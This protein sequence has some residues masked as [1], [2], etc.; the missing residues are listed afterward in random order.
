MMES[1]HPSPMQSA[2]SPESPGTIDTTAPAIVFEHVSFAFDDQ[3]VLAD[4][5]FSV[6]KS[7]M[8]FLLG[9]SGSG[10]STVLKL[11]LGLLRPDSGTILVNGQDI[12]Q[13]SERELLT[14]RA[15]I[16][17][18]FQ[19][20]ALFDSLTV[21]ENVGYRLYEETQTPVDEV[22]ARVAEVLG[23]IG[24]ED[25]MDRMPAELSGGQRRRVGLAR[26]MATRPGLLLFDD[27]TTGLDP[28]TAVT[29]NDEIVKLRDIEGVT[30]IV[31]THQMRDAFYVATHRASRTNGDIRIDKSDDGDAASEFMVLQEG[32]IV[33][34]GPA[35]E[36]LS[37]TDPYLT[38]F[39]FKTLPPW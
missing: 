28:I 1:R 18:V 5:S 15:D 32:R 26:A 30:S 22:R 37:S 12:G 13:M 16:G 24:L 33:F 23:F 6:P 31:A 38:E 4:V 21:N 11:I 39:L 20:H 29:V 27:P 9:S 10:K 14:L 34:E 35:A 25:F 8:R 19:E 36:L 3:V 17:M 7:S 2:P